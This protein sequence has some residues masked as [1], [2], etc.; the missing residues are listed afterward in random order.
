MPIYVFVCPDC[1]RKEERLRRIDDHSTQECKGCGTRMVAQIS[2]PAIV[3]GVHE[4]HYLVPDGFKTVLKSIQNGAPR[5]KDDVMSEM[6]G[7]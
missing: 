4:L 6:K 2:A 5:G 7:L 3:S 1:E